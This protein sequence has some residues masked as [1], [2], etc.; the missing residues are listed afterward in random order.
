MSLFN[1]YNQIYELKN[2]NSDNFLKLFAD[3]YGLKILNYQEYIHLLDSSETLFPQDDFIYYSFKTN[4]LQNIVNLFYYKR[5]EDKNFNFLKMYHNY[6]NR[7]EYSS[8]ELT[9]VF[10][11]V[12]FN[13]DKSLYRKEDK[14][15]ILFETKISLENFIIIK[16]LYSQ[17]YSEYHKESL[18][19]KLYFTSYIVNELKNTTI[20]LAYDKNKSKYSKIFSQ[21]M[22]DFFIS[23]HQFNWDCE[24]FVQD[25]RTCNELNNY[26][27]EYYVSSQYE[28]VNFILKPKSIDVSK[29]LKI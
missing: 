1:L 4:N 24:K 13:L 22:L 27:Y 12:F 7:I 11:L 3:L 23:E 15:P 26:L 2:R 10:L 8:F 19:E 21:K 20:F 9:Y 25:R 28:K 16:S 14:L 18:N 29:I 17:I 6:I 5:E